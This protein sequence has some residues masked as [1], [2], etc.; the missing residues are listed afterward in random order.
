MDGTATASL[1]GDPFF[2]CWYDGVSHFGNPF[3]GISTAGKTMRLVT[4]GLDCE[5]V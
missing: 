3:V 1:D 5:I 4:M 2:L